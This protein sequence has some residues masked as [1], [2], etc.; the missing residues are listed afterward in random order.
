MRTLS[1]RDIKIVKG[2]PPLAVRG[3]KVAL[4]SEFFGQ[5]KRRLHRPHG[6]FA[7]LGATFDGKT[8]YYITDPEQIQE[9]LDQ[10]ESAVWIFHN[11]KYDITQLRRFAR[12]PMRNKLWDTML[13]EQI[14]YSGYYDGFS[15]A[16]LA[17]RRLDLYLA[18]DVRAEFSVENAPEPFGGHPDLSRE[19]LEYSSMDVAATWMVY[20]DQRAEIDDND[21]NIWKEIELPFLWTIMAMS[22]VK[23]DTESWITLAKRNEESAKRI[24]DKYGHWTVEP[25]TGRAKK[26][27]DIFV[28]V[29]LNSPAQIKKHFSSGGVHLKS[30]DAE[31][32]EKI[33]AEGDDDS[34]E[35]R[36]ANDLLVYRTY[37]KR[38]STYGE[39]FITDYVEEDGRIY[40]DIYQCGAETGRTSSR[41]PNLQNQPHEI[42]Y[43]SCF[44][45][46]EGMCMVVADWGAQEPRIAAYLSQDPR[47]IE[48]MNSDKKLYIEIA[49]DVF[50]REITKEMEEYKHIKSTVLGIFYGMSAQGLSVRLG[51]DDGSAQEMIDKILATYP[52]IQEYIDRQFKAGD[53]V[54]SVYGRKIWM[55]KHSN[56][57]QRNALNAPIQGS[58]ADAMK[59]AAFRFVD[60]CDEE[61]YQGSPLRLLVHD[62][63]VLEIEEGNVAW[64]METLERIMIEVAEEMHDGIKG[65]VEIFSGSSWA[66]KH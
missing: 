26:D 42:E 36:F 33:I 45:A 48:I 31:A 24:Q 30:T 1:S 65:S 25:A 38:A 61:V 4:D 23:L 32:L 40:G 46:G 6:T 13:I 64:A 56:Q 58:A 66:C 10:L 63:I 29:N 39:K 22:G 5:E 54:Q 18:K 49:R 28:G 27:K 43:R 9:F 11:A 17:R 14:M 16:D 51:I 62:E 34:F 21:L 12:I 55:N 8:V 50:G 37:A 19:Q 2:I 59:I 7:Y 53:Y 41:S 44:I 52:G 3:D 47:L 57:W 15:L 35:W 20:Q 60:A